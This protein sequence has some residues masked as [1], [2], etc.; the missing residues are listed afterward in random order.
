[1]TGDDEVF[2]A[3]ADLKD[4]DSL[5]RTVEGKNGPLGFTRLFINKPTI[6]AVAGY[7]VAGGLELALWCDLRIADETA[8]FRSAYR[9][10][11]T[12]FTAHHRA[13]TGSSGA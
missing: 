11:D 13:W 5:A 10:R 7:Y 2:C 3:G 4:I 8:V 9:R 12:V 1:L 6:A